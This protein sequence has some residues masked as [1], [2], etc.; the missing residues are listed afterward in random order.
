MSYRYEHLTVSRVVD[1]ISADGIYYL[2]YSFLFG[3]SVWVNFIGGVIAYR[4]LPR[5]AFSSL[6]HRTFPV[7]FSTSQLISSVLLIIWT[8]SHPDVL[9]NWYNPVIADVAQAWCLA[10]VLLTQGANDWVVGPLTSNTMFERQKLEKEEGKSY[11]DAGVSDK[12]KELNK[13]FGMLHGVSYLLSMGAVVALAFHGL[14]LG[15]VGLRG[16]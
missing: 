6:Q 4:A 15:N 13:R 14:W 3:M 10:T 9:T 16:Y 7:F 12:M 5:Q 1:L 11:N 2:G 8:L